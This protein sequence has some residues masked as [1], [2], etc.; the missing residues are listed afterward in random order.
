MTANERIKI[1]LVDD[2]A[3]YREAFKRTLL[4]EEYDVCEAADADE[5]IEAIQSQS[6]DIVVTDLQMRTE[7]EGLELIETIKISD[8]LMPVIMISAVGSFE[9]GAL[10]T[11]MGAAHV[12]HKSRIEEEMD[13]FFETIR[14]S[15]QACR[16]SRSQLALVAR[17]RQ[18]R[19]L[20]DGDE[21]LEA[22]MELID[23][24]NVDP[25]VQS[26]AYDFIISINEVELLRESELDMQHASASDRDQQTY[27]AALQAIEERLPGYDAMNEDSKKA[28]ATAE[29]LCAAKEGSAMLDFSR[30]IAFSYCFA[31][32]NE[33]R[34]KLKG[35]V[36]RL[37]SNNSNRRIFEACI[38]PKTR[39]M[40]MLFQQS[41]LMAKRSGDIRFTMDNVR[42][43]ILGILQRGNKFRIDGL[44]D[45]G[46]ILLCFGRKYSFP[47]RGGT[48]DVRN[49]LRVKGLASEREIIHLAGRLIELQYARNPYIHPEVK[50]KMAHLSVL[51]ETAFE[52]LDIIGKLA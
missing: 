33:V 48:I 47:K 8:P 32:E 35:N 14:Q 34:A 42:Y 43:V 41:L 31:V 19:N 2:N 40:D 17:A 24:P 45:M 21:S 52:C 25:H 44:K 9:E 26:E 27:A 4:L 49:P 18:Q 38:D 3:Q 46:I 10:A 12:I 29:Y 37:A 13:S 28:L 23:D 30:T 11:K 7:R 51:R 6:P 22:V 1:L 39:R 5:A 50:K 20:K 16:K 15:Y 36:T